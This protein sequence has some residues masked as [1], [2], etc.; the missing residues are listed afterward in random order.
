MPHQLVS[1]RL[2]RR[3]VPPLIRPIRRTLPRRTSR[4]AFPVQVHATAQTGPDQTTNRTQLCDE[5]IHAPPQDM[6]RQTRPHDGP[7]LTGPFDVPDPFEL[8]DYLC[9][10][11]LGDIPR[12]SFSSDEPGRAVPIDQPR[13][14]H[15]VDA[16]RRTFSRP[17]TCLLAPHLAARRTVPAPSHPCDM[18][19]HTRPNQSTGHARS[20]QSTC[21]TSP[22]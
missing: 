9:Q 11:S 2:T 20:S 22:C 7:C 18:P 4:H 16:L 12:H 3:A 6:P 19:H 17:P 21:H 10:A 5:P 13:H 15:S 14:A 1:Y 8:V